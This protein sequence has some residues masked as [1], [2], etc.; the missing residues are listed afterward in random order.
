MGKIKDTDYL[1]LSARVRAMERTLLTR[2]RMERMLEARTDEEAVKVLTECG[3]AELSPV[4]PEGVERLLTQRRDALF[5]DLAGGM[6]E[7]KLLEV[8]QIKYDYHNLKVLLKAEA[9][10]QEADRLLVRTGRVPPEVLKRRL[11]DPD[12][13]SLPPRLEA[14]LREGR[15]L[16][17]AT[18]DPQRLDLALD[19]ACF[20]DMT[21]L[22]EQTGSSYLK[23]YTALLI[24]AANLRALV[25]AARMGKGPEFLKGVLLE[26]GTVPPR[27]L[28]T[29]AGGDGR[30]LEEAYGATAL[31]SAAAL[32]AA[33]LSAGSLT[34]FEKACD[35]AVLRYL[36]G[37]RY[38]PFGEAPVIGYLAAVDSELTNL[39]ILLSGR[40][41]GLEGET[42]RERLRE[43]YV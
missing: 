25:R 40:M 14:A 2:E 43:S 7:P 4:T 42:I 28:L 38:V 20:A 5:R 21:A 35:D 27:R 3:Y 1:S 11:L 16:L 8:F 10:G 26:G 33:A 17:A 34:G 24:D 39:R 9:L 15:E 30:A 22:A 36:A 41:A 18:G 37:A 29:L 6:P 32:G 19:R 23:G 12:R 31:K 13:G